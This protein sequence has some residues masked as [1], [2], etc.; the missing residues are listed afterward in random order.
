METENR[1]LKFLHIPLLILTNAASI[2]LLG[3]INHKFTGGLHDQVQKH[4]TVTSVIVNIL[5]T[6]L[7][8]A[9]VY[10]LCT[11][12]SFA[13]RLRTTRNFTRANSLRILGALS[14]PRIDWGLKWYAMIGTA[15]FCLIGPLLGAVWTG[16]LTPL[17]DELTREDGTILTPLY[18]GPVDQAYHLD[19]GGVIYLNC[20][21]LL[22]NISQSMSVSRCPAIGHITVL[23]SSA[24]SAT[25]S[26]NSTRINPKID[27]PT[28]SYVNRSYG[29]GASQGLFSPTAKSKHAYDAYSYDE[30]GYFSKVT[31]GFNETSN[32]TINLSD[33]GQDSYL[34]VWRVEGSL[35]NTEATNT[36]SY[37]LTTAASDWYDE[38]LGWSAAAANGRNMLAIATYNGKEVGFGSS[39]P[40]HWY[41]AW[42]QM[43]C[44]ITFTP[45][46]FNVSVNLTTS[47]ISV[48][49][50]DS[51]AKFE[52]TSMQEVVMANIDLISRMSSNVGVSALGVALWDNANTV[53]A[54][55]S[56]MADNEVLAWGAENMIKALVDDLL[57]A[58]ASQQMAF[59]N[60]GTTA[61]PVRKVFKAVRLGSPRFIYLALGINIAL[62][63][64][65]AVETIRTRA[66][67]GLT[68]FNFTNLHSV[69]A[70]A[71]L[72]PP[73][74][75]NA[76]HADEDNDITTAARNLQHASIRWWYNDTND[77]VMLVRP[78][79]DSSG[80][81][82]LQPSY[83]H[84]MDP[85][86]STT[87]A[88]IGDSSFENQEP[89]PSINGRRRSLLKRASD[90]NG[91]LKAAALMVSIK[92]DLEA[93]IH[94]TARVLGDKTVGLY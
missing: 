86:A 33:S 1:F 92:L 67:R 48:S 36:S 50:K 28:W 58:E 89:F 71:M 60:N 25:P 80:D 19:P 47:R 44:S 31:C 35:P 38:V 20:N 59:S 18:T 74:Q 70:A 77:V 39:K 83:S 52:P 22:S 5:A 53:N 9:Q 69:M 37:T 45:T 3:L 56:N 79:G 32:L 40:D 84:S 81:E 13:T 62:V 65:V 68:A 72:S 41:R 46:L 8:A 14:A 64:L 42:N 34:R 30:P 91:N 90:E 85:S 82:M 2:T 93:E 66:W 23:L 63:L 29:V 87:G 16:A 26:G 73:P 49:P 76:S 54:S 7:A 43:Q 51:P 15:I 21:Q 55:Y 12:I 6:L 61:V 24:Q 10:A 11:L 78:P 75:K 17:L 4:R 27:D 88:S 57:G 94:L